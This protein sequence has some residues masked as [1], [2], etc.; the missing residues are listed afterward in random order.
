MERPQRRRRRVVFGGGLLDKFGWNEGQE[1]KLRDK[2]EGKNYSLEYA[3]K[4]C[5]WGSKSDMNIYMSIDD[6]NEL[7]GND[8]AYF[9]GYVSDEKLD[10]DA[11]YFAGDTTPDDMRAVGDQSST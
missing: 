1:V 8:A 4:D 2:Y 5:A 7:F 3:G 9:N 6:F 10:L 11:R